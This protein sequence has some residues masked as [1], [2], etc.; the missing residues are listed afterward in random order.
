M[1]DKRRKLTDAQIRAMR[2]KRKLGSYLKEL[3]SEF[4]CSLNWVARVTNHKDTFRKTA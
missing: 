3:A 2:E 4:N 1:N